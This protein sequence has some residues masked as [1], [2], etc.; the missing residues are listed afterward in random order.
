MKS[1][2]RVLEER[3]KSFVEISLEEDYFEAYVKKLVEE[4]EKEEGRSR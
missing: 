3:N 4:K 2:G 1:V